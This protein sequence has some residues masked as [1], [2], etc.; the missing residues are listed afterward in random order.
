MK[1]LAAILYMLFLSSCATV[2]NSDFTAI[3][4]YTVQDS[5]RICVGNNDTG[6]CRF[7]PARF[8]VFRSKYPLKLTVLNDGMTKDFTIPSKLS[9]M[10]LW[11]NI[12]NPLFP[13]GHVVDLTNENRFTYPKNVLIDFYDS[14]KTN[15]RYKPPESSKIYETEPKPKDYK[16][17]V[18]GETGSV[19]IKFS[20]PEGNSLHIRNKNGYSDYFGFLGLT[21]EAGYYYAQNKYFSAGTGVITDFLL[22]IPAPVDYWG[23]HE[24][25]SGYYFD[26]NHGHQYERYTFSYGLHFSG[27]VFRHSFSNRF[28]PDSVL[29]SEEDTIPYTIRE[30]AVG[31]SLSAKYGLTRY[32]HLG[33]RYLPAITNIEIAGDKNY[34]H[35]LFLDLIFNIEFRPEKTKKKRT[36]GY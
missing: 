22:P 25:A 26:L 34:S 5:A 20:V 30:N 27:N 21:T 36:T 31:I 10:F 1:N 14:S 33:I 32:F 15:I 18:S 16:R 17:K 4:V 35:F 2:L 29:Y 19:F 11:G 3:S 28:S 6:Y 12:F 13:F 7:S 8:H 23:V 24:T 9:G